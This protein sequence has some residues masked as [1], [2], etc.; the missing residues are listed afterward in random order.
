MDTSQAC[1]V[2]ILQN[3]IAERH[4]VEVNTRVN[5]PLKSALRWMQENDVFELECPGDKYCVSLMTGILCQVGIQLHTSSWNN[6]RIPGE[7]F[8]LSW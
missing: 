8:L 1:I 5:Y 6:H 4:W 7:F 3:H 2:L